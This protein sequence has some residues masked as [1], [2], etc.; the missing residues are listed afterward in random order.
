MGRRE[1][2]ANKLGQIGTQRIADR[3]EFEQNGENV[4]ERKDSEVKDPIHS[5][6][7][8]KQKDIVKEPVS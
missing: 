7:T 5:A 3:V 1:D 8:S 4:S 6:K 2:S